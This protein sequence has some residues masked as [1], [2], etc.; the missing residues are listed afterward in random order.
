MRM[1]IAIV[2]GASSGLGRAFCLALKARRSDISEYWLVARRGERLKELEL[3]LRP[4]KVRIFPLDLTQWQSL[5]ALQSALD[6]E[7]PE[8]ALLINNAGFGLLGSVWEL[9]PQRQRD[10]ANLNCG[11]VTALTPI[12]LNHMHKGAA[13][14]NVSSI[15][16]FAP[17]PRMSVYCAT[18]SYVT[19]YTRS[20]RFELKSRGINALTLC[21]GPMDTEFLPIAGITGHSKTFDHLPRLDPAKVAKGALKAA[22]RGRGVYTPG[23]FF[24]LYRLIAKV[25]PH[26]LVMRFSK[27]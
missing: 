4:M 22:F 16:S 7:Q 9:S 2:T 23:A 25:L 26:N 11:A 5:E 18:K 12:V 27:T 19:A 13:I 20:L 14:I 21:P 15:A 6:R 17:T 3:L 10:M 8:V 1:S 24:R